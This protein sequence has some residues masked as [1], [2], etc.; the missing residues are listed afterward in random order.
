MDTFFFLCLFLE[1]FFWA[2]ANRKLSSNYENK[3]DFGVWN[4][5]ARPALNIKAFAGNLDK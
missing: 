4:L 5:N 3:E 2:K 1:G